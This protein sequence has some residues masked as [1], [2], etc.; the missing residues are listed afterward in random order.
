[1][2]KKSIMTYGDMTPEPPVEEP[3]QF[4]PPAEEPRKVDRRFK[5]DKSRAFTICTQEGREPY[6]EQDGIKYDPADGR[7][8]KED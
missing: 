3:T 5:I 4:T 6:W 7:P 1:M 8:L 2:A